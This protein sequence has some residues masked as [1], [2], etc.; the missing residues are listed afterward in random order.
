MGALPVGQQGLLERPQDDAGQRRGDGRDT[1]PGADHPLD[2]VD[3]H[4]GQLG[5]KLVTGHVVRLTHAPILP[6]P[7]QESLTVPSGRSP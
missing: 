2:Q 4:L 3:L 7:S 5:P 1:D 6:D